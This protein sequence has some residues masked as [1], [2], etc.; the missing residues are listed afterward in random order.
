MFLELLK[1]YKDHY[2]FKLFAYC[3]LPDHFHLLLE[4]P[5]QKEEKYKVGLLSNITHDL[6]SSYTKYFNRKYGRKGHLFRG[7]Y[8]SALIEKETQLLRISAYIHLNPQRLNL[9]SSA[10]DY[11]F[12]SYVFYLNREF[13]FS[14]LMKDEKEEVLSLLNGQGYIGFIEKI[15]K[16][17]DF[18]HL[19]NYLQKGILGTKDFAEKVKQAF[20]VY[21]KERIAA[22]L[23][24][25]RKL[26]IVS[27]IVVLTGL[28]ITFILR[29]SWEGK[30]KKTT[31]SQA[32]A[33][34]LPPKIKEL[35]RGLEN[36]EWQI[37]IVSKAEGRVDNDVVH[38]E[39]GKFFSRNH[40]L[41]NYPPLD[42][43]L[44][45]DDDN[46]ITWQTTQAAHDGVAVLWQGEIKK[47]EIEGGLRLRY[48]NGKTEDY[49][50]VSVGSSRRQ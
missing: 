43:F 40:S 32:I 22:G 18:P 45:I 2:K 9:V 48:S 27:L 26:G 37:R 34:K 12:S 17:A 39:E 13:P 24:L 19:H 1:K 10:Q 30:S 7:R 38:F 21:K 23:G 15:I 47:G 49:S 20:S 44:V 6:N 16:E 42:Y 11:P 4:L 28:G 31:A 8:K 3:L 36:T 50:F 46:K 33:Y 41:K 35:I 29:L 14:N 5:Q 25:G